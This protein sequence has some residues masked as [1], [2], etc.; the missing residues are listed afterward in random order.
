MIKLITG[1]AE[2]PHITSADDGELYRH[3]AKKG[4]YVCADDLPLVTD[5]GGAVINDGVT[6]K[7]VDGD[8]ELTVEG[9]AFFICS[10]FVR[11][12]GSTSITIPAGIVGEVISRYICLSYLNDNGIESV[13]LILSNTAEN[14]ST[15]YGGATEYLMPLFEV[16]WSGTVITVSNIYNIYDSF[17]CV[18]NEVGTQ[19]VVFPNTYG[20]KRLTFKNPADSANPHD[21]SIYGGN[22]DST[23]LIGVYDNLNQK[24]IWRY[25]GDNNRFVDTNTSLIERNALSVY[26]TSDAV[27]SASESRTQLNCDKK[28]AGIGNRLIMTSGGIEI[29]A[30]VKCVKTGGNIYFYTGTYNDTKTGE[31]VKASKDGT[32]SA[33]AVV[34]IRPTSGYLHISIPERLVTV[35]EG[36]AIRLCITGA[37]SDRIKS[38]GTGT[39][40]TVE[41]MG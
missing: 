17:T 22:A 26:M 25:I 3:L 15:I 2:A 38:Y 32:V 33:V 39:F 40:L 12:I 6:E 21:V 31:I 34:N 1:R 16:K 35:S 14:S 29:G 7:E 18:T 27:L 11:N 36:D 10:R 9:G 13:D 5:S 20:E 24:F 41:V 4:D 28:V 37:K 8:I 30:G 23:S 19:E